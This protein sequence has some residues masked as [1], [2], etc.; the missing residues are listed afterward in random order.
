MS[1]M[2]NARS[3][4][5][6]NRI[7]SIIRTKGKTYK[8][9]IK[10]ISR[11]SMV[12]VLD[13][14]EQLEKENLI[15]YTGKG[16]TKNGRRPNYIEL[17]PQAHFFCGLSFNASEISLA[18]LDFCGA[19]RDF[20]N[21]VIPE[22]C[23]NKDYVFSRI[24]TLLEDMLNKHSNLRRHIKGIGIGT[25]G[26]VDD[27]QSIFY[28]HIPDWRNVPVADLIAE[29]IQ[30][31]PIYIENI[32]N[33]IALGYKWIGPDPAPD[34]CVIISI[35][36]GVRMSLLTG[37]S[38]HRGVSF[39][40]GEIGHTSV[41]GGTRY[42]PCGKQG[43]LDTEVSEISL[44]HKILEGI[45]VGQFQEMWNMAGH[46]EQEINTDLFFASVRQGH[47]DSLHL[48]DE[49]SNYLGSSIGQI[50][51]IVNP[52]KVI[53]SSRYCELEDLFFG[54]LKQSVWHK[55][56]DVSL[57]PLIIE[58]IAFGEYASAMGAAAIVMER[59]LGYVDAII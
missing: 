31:I 23:R 59:T 36:S 38:L 2:G 49:I 47:K 21:E 51:N 55:A 15:I 17:N 13:T 16:V 42:C 5:T 25:P 24:Y 58:P 18:L 26:Y 35:R 19:R 57:K 9:E 8:I 56:I 43:C 20:Y 41:H 22:S 48:L 30:D 45:N 7:L 32:V 39:T 37:N 4:N 29:R 54:R 10:K 50:I 46:D 28:P 34:N 33:A 12:T 11:Y 27:R 1:S 52:S 3:T 40:A 53:I 6:R 14:I 44:R